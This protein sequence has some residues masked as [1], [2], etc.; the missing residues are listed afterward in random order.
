MDTKIFA[1]SRGRGL[2][3]QIYLK[4]N[5]DV[6]VCYYKGVTIEDMHSCIKGYSGQYQV[7]AAYLLVGVN[8]ITEYDE[9]LCKYYVKFDTPEELRDSLTE[10]MID[11]V[12]CCKNECHIDTVVIS[13]ITGLSLSAYNGTVELD[14]NQ[15]I[16]D[17]GLRHLNIDINTINAANC[18][19]TPMVHQYVHP[20]M[21]NRR[22]ARNTYSRLRDGIHPT[23]RTLGKWAEALI[24]SM[25]LNGHLP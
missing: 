12:K 22:R 18:L 15:W 11:L 2:S 1:D 6:E 24:A 25:R 13:T 7:G 4:S 19:T 17:E 9:D 20:S 5:R 16:I 14:V 21:G 23:I 3:R 8:N 10:S